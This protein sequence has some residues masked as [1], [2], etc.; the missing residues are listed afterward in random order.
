[1]ADAIVPASAPSGIDAVPA[2][3]GR[4]KKGFLPVFIARNKVGMIGY[5]VFAAI[6]IMSFIGPLFL[7]DKNPT[8]VGLIYATPSWDHPLGTDWRGQDVLYQIING[9]SSLLIVSTLAAA[10]A[11]VI[12]VAGGGLAALVGGRLDAGVLVLADVALTI[13]FI[14]LLGVLAVYVDLDNV[15]MLAAVLAAFG[16]PTLLRAVRAQA[17]SLKAQPYVEAARMLGTPLWLVLARAVV[18][19]MMPYIVIS[20]V[21]GVT[22]AIYGQVILYYLGLVPLQGDNWGLMIQQI[23]STQAYA[24]DDALVYV[25]APIAMISLLQLSLILI[26]RSLDNVFDPRLRTD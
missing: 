4:R 20:F 14:I 5:V 15:L 18:P 8:D 9:G 25:V 16:W 26:A 11:T 2:G 17:L 23:Q 12:A 24:L 13:P 19:S 7:P 3:F 21:L 1:M 22:H 6:L 10:I